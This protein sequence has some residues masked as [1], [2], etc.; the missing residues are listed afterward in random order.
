MQE[1][2]FRGT[3]RRHL[4]YFINSAFSAVNLECDTVKLILTVNL[5]SVNGIAF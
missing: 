2:R 4:N 1:G 5:I 3:H